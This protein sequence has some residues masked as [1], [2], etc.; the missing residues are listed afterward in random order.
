MQIHRPCGEQPPANRSAFRSAAPLAAIRLTLYSLT[1]MH[2]A[3]L[4]NQS[5]IREV[6]LSSFEEARIV[7]HRFAGMAHLMSAARQ[8]RFDAVILEAVSDRVP[9][10]LVQLRQRFGAG[11][12]VIVF[13]FDNCRDMTNSLRQGADDCCSLVEGSSALLLR[14]EVRVGLARRHAR[15]NRLDAGPVS[16]DAP[17]QSLHWEDEQISLTAREFAL[18]WTLFEHMGSVV[19][20]ASLS[21]AIWGRDDEVGKRAIEQHVYKLRRKLAT[22]ARQA[23]GRMPTIQAVYGVGY[24]VQP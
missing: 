23:A 12:P 4:F 18:A 24:R 9:G 1:I 8:Q 22:R 2:I 5:N 10:W 13:G 6:A 21:T 7:L 20:L 14:V 16:L 15:S 3:T 19:T 17:T 11:L